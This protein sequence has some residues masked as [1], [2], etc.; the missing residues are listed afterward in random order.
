MM[1]GLALG[2]VTVAGVAACTP[3]ADDSEAGMG[4]PVVGWLPE[5]PAGGE[6]MTGTLRVASNGCF[7]LEIDDAQ[8]FA[9]WPDEFAHAG[10]EVRT[11][12][13]TLLGAGDPIQGT[14][15]VLP[16][17][18]AVGLGGPDS[19]LAQAI[20]YCAEDMDVVVLTEV[21]TPGS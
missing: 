18:T 19:Q 12:D 10:A 13:G 17:N 14:G 15:A 21:S 9:L 16:H 4:L 3:Q 7:H 20:D 8:L 11:D 6:P 1:L 5:P 2:G